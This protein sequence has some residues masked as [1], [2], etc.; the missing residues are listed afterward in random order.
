MR[1]L[2]CLLLL[3][4]STAACAANA[5]INFTCCAYTPTS[6]TIAPGDSV[7]WNGS[8]GPHPLLQV[9]G[10]SSNTAVPGGFSATSGSTFTHTF[11]TPGT[12]HF[13]CT[14]HGTGVGGMRGT[15]IVQ[16][17]NVYANGFE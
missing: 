4:S 17:D 16:S 15:V 1:H 9:D 6:V 5:T 11:N 2:L 7:T 12:Y 3:L 13:Q 8:F 10:P 14:V